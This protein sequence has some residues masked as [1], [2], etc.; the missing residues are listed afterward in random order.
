FGMSNKDASVMT[1][2]L[3]LCLFFEACEQESSNGLESAKWLLNAGAKLSNERG[4]NIEDLGITPEQVAGIISLRKENKI[5]S[6]AA[7]TIFELLCDSDQTAEAIAESNSLLQVVD[8]DALATW[9]QEA[10]EAQPQAADDV[11]NGKDAAIGRLIG[12]IMKRSGGSA[13]AGAARTK[14]LS[15]LQP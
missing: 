7:N 6:S 2:E 1:S 4:C 5:G 3:G 8:E 11:R 10:I 14:L 12:E 15:T 13:D 9:V